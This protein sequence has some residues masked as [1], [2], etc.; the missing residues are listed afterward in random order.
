MGA[1]WRHVGTTSR[2]PRLLGFLA[3]PREDRLEPGLSG[4][5][6]LVTWRG[7]PDTSCHMGW[8][9]ITTKQPPVR[10]SQSPRLQKPEVAT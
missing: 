8:T 7:F 5:D 3:V 4:T 9:S 10:F 6:N 1:M 2:S